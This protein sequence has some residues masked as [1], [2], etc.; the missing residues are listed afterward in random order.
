MILTWST[1]QLPPARTPER[2]ETE[3][4]FMRNGAKNHPEGESRG[5]EP[6]YAIEVLLGCL[7]GITRGIAIRCIHKLSVNGLDYPMER[8]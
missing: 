8:V 3:V 7:Y 2:L 4:A 1:I 5:N 6:R